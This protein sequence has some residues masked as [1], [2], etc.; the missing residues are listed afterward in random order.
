MKN[1]QIYI[2][3]FHVNFSFSYEQI[4]L[5]LNVWMMFLYGVEITLRIINKTIFETKL[6]GGPI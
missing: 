3:T 1:K 5:F 2:S 4:I 6:E